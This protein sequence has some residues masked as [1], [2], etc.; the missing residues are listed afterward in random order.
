[1][2]PHTPLASTPSVSPH[3]SD[4][5]VYEDAREPPLALEKD[6]SGPPPIVA[7]SAPDQ[8]AVP[9][10][11]PVPVPELPAPAPSELAQVLA[12]LATQAQQMAAIQAEVKEQKAATKA[13]CCQ[14]PRG[15]VSHAHARSLAARDE[16]D[17]PKER[18]SQQLV[19]VIAPCTFHTSAIL[20]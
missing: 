4:G 5:K 11:V 2:S 12:A 7:A 8:A 15:R 18:P 19:F 9:A 16:V 17:T 6:T 1:M 14:S 20:L 10:A 3:P 13:V